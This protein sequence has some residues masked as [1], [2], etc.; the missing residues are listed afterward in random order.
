M[1]VNLFQKYL[2][3]SSLIFSEHIIESLDISLISINGK[4]ASNLQEIRLELLSNSG[5]TGSID[6]VFHLETAKAQES[7][8]SV[9]INNFLSTAEEQNAPENFLGFDLALK[10]QP[11]RW[12][13][14]RRILWLYKSGLEVNDRI[15]A[16]N[17][18]PIYVI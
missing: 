3:I 2:E 4:E 17:S 14:M 10:M 18:Q 12:R 7:T 15:L 5:E 6:L 13:N 1:S 11:T 8:L 9:P 16:V